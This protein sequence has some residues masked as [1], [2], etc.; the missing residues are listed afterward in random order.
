MARGHSVA[1]AAVDQGVSRTELV[2]FP[3]FS[4]LTKDL[5]EYLFRGTDLTYFGDTVASARNAC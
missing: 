5:H 1:A 4:C 2:Q 3:A